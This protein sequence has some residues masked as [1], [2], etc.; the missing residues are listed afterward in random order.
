MK[1][2]IRIAEILR[3]FADQ[4]EDGVGLDQYKKLELASIYVW[5][6]LPNGLQVPAIIRKASIDLENLE[7]PETGELNNE[8]D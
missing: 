7:V 5:G 8:E 3:T 1:E 4:V 2:Q 6:T